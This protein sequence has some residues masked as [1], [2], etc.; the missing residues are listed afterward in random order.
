MDLP[1]GPEYVLGPGDSAAT[2]A[3]MYGL[4]VSAIKDANPSVNFNKLKPGDAI[5]IPRSPFSPS[6]SP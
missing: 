2:I 4:P 1:A 5:T 6:A 3:M